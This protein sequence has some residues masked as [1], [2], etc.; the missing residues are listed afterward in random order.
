MKGS[1]DSTPTPNQHYHKDPQK[2]SQKNKELINSYD[3]G[4]DQ[5]VKKTEHKKR[6]SSISSTATASTLKPTA[7]TSKRRESVGSAVIKITPDKPTLTDAES[8]EI[9]L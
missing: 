2:H 6:R 4:L 3:D 5:I 9:T 1:E 7:T 8:K